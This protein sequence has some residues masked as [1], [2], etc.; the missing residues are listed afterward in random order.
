[1]TALHRRAARRD[2]A[3]PLIVAALRAHGFS[4]VPLSAKGVGDLL[5][6]K[7]HITRIVEV[8]TDTGAL[9]PDQVTWWAAW[10]GNPLIILRTLDDVD[11][12]ARSWGGDSLTR[13]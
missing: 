9:T 13:N 3:E 4:V 10:R 11:R 2:I 6:G 1:M 12:L 8:K 7:N 5:L